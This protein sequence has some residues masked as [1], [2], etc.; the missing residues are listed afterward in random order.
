MCK[1]FDFCINADQNES[2]YFDILEI[3]LVLSIQDKKVKKSKI[4]MTQEL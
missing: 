2:E 1:K 4:Q 3:P